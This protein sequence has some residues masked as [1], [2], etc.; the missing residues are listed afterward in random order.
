MRL[1]EYIRNIR[2]IK[3]L[4]LYDLAAKSKITYCHLSRIERGETE[5]LR[6]DTLK[7]ISKA[8]NIGIH[9]LVSI[10]SGELA[11][12]AIHPHSEKHCVVQG[13]ETPEMNFEPLAQELKGDLCRS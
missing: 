7:K 13:M 8:L 4:R 1:G 2:K 3:G 9:D 11:D 5:N 12:P 6:L 10:I